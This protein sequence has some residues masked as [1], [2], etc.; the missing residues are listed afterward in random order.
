MICVSVSFAMGVPVRVVK[1][2]AINSH[3][4]ISIFSPLSRH[5][6]IFDELGWDRGVP[7]LRVCI[8]FGVIYQFLHSWFSCDQCELP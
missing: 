4:F 7:V 6:H 3:D 8:P 2:S 5:K 1:V